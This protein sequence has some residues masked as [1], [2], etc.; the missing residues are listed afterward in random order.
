MTT[1]QVTSSH[2]DAERLLRTALENYALSI[3]SHAAQCRHRNLNP[4]ETRDQLDKRAAVL[5]TRAT[6]VRE[7]A[8][9][10]PGGQAGTTTTRK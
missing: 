2:P 1:I 4:G 8:E 3:T 6:A 7:M 9:Q 5:D 10:I